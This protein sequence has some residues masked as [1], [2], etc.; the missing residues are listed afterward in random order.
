MAAQRQQLYYLRK[1]VRL[2][3]GKKTTESSRALEARVAMPEAKTDNS[4]DKSLFTDL[5]LKL[6]TEIIQL[7]TERETIPDRAKQILDGWDRGQ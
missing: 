3:K 7:S 6:I 4:S 5:S 1:K 2:I